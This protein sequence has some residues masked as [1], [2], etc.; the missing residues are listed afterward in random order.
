MSDV[1]SH[2]NR[3]TWR[4]VLSEPS[5]ADIRRARGDLTQADAAAMAGLA[6]PVRWT[7]YESGTRRPHWALWELFL[8]VTDQHPTRRLIDR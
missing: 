1:P 8:L 4:S 2:P 5:P 6:S 7:E 3:S